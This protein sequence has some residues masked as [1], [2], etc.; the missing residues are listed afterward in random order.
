MI[1]GLFEAHEEKKQDIRVL[2]RARTLGKLDKKAYEASL[3]S[4]PDE[5]ERG[6]YVNIDELNARDNPV[7][8]PRGIPSVDGPVRRN[9]EDQEFDADEANR[10]FEH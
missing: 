9:I 3:K 2:D 10:S 7:H 8:I 5:A 6:T 4:L 1:R